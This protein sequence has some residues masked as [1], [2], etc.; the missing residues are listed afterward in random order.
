MPKIQLS[1]LATDMKGKSGG[2]VFARNK[3]GLYF[4]NNP[5]AVQKKSFSWGYQKAKFTALSTSWR[6][7]T[8]EQRIAWEEAGVNYPA[9]DAWGNSYIPSGYQLYMRLN[10]TLSS[11]DF[12]LI[13]TPAS[14]GTWPEEYDNIGSYSPNLPAFTPKK[15]ASLRG[16]KQSNYYLISKDYLTNVDMAGLNHLSMRFTRDIN[17]RTAYS[18]S[19]VVRLYSM[20]DAD[21]YGSFAAITFN[22][23]NKALLVVAYNYACPDYSAYSQVSIYDIN[24]AWLSGQF[25]FTFYANMDYTDT[26]ILEEGTILDSRVYCNGELINAMSVDYYSD[27]QDPYLSP[28][29]PKGAS[30]TALESIVSTSWTATLRVGN[31]TQHDLRVLNVSDIRFYDISAMGNNGGCESNEDCPEDYDCYNGECTLSYDSE[32]K[33]NDVKYKLIFRGYLLGNETA[34]T[35]LNAYIDGEFQTISANELP[36]LSLTN[37][38]DCCSAGSDCEDFSDQECRDCCCIYVGDDAWSTPNLNWTFS[39]FVLITPIGLQGTNFGL[40][41]YCTKPL[42]LGRSGFNQQYKLASTIP[43]WIVPTRGGSAPKAAPRIKSIAEPTS[44]DVSDAIKNIVASVPA[45]TAVYL[46]YRVINIETGEQVECKPK[47]PPYP[48]P[49]RFK[50]GSELS[51]S[52]N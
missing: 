39:P 49:I 16:T 24:D 26:D 19:D 36:G 44:Y 37:D 52:V 12:D 4:R 22:K 32:T 10:G 21:N 51:S 31:Y 33:W 3:G 11:Y 45:D 42:G 23:Q 6:A 48:N 28:L 35:P 13:S 30:V 18:Q 47:R 5:G 1:A 46:S 41:V 2:S 50:A 43:P 40:A 27:I 8:N 34:V 9:Q 14:P 7:L 20:L 38:E 17:D 15:C 25:H 29:V